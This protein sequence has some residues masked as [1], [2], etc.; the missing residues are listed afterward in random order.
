LRQKYDHKT[1]SFAASPD[2]TEISGRSRPPCAPAAF[3][4]A[5]FGKA[6]KCNPHLTDVLIDSVKQGDGSLNASG[7]RGNDPLRSPEPPAPQQS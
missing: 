2:K 5:E 3:T 7:H 6:L 4:E 1:G